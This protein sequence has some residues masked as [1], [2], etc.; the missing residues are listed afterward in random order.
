MNP[1]RTCII[2]WD[3]RLYDYL[4]SWEWDLESDNRDVADDNNNNNN[5]NNSNKN[6]RK[7]KC[8]DGSINDVDEGEEKQPALTPKQKFGGGNVLKDSNDNNSSHSM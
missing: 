2:K 7:K 3:S 6:D 5:N 8:N 1:I 4:Y